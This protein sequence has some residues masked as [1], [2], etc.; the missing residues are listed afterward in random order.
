MEN[1][2]LIKGVRIS[3]RNW[4]IPMYGNNHS[5]PY[6]TLRVRGEIDGK[7]VDV[8][9]R[10]KGDL[11]GDCTPQYVVINRKRYKVR[12]LGTMYFPQLSLER[13]DKEKIGGRWMYTDRG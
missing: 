3:L 9:V 5:I 2:K 13:W 1:E 4:T 10:T 12:N 11:C 8:I 7:Q 6:G